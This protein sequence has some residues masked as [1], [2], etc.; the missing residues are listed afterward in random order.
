MLLNRIDR[1]FLLVYNKRNNEHHP[2]SYLYLC[3]N[4]CFD[5][6]YFRTSHPHLQTFRNEFHRG[7]ATPYAE[8]L[9]YMVLNN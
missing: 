1:V 4:R 2:I 5:M 6:Y 3:I 8:L 7:I 9:N